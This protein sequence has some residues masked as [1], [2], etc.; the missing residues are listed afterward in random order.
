MTTTGS[1]NE[2]ISCAL[3]AMAGLLVVLA[4][5]ALVLLTPSDPLGRVTLTAEGCASLKLAGGNP[6]EL[7]GV[8]VV[9]GRYHRMLTG[10]TTLVLPSD[11][12]VTLSSRAVL[13]VTEDDSLKTDEDVARQ[14]RGFLVFG[15]CLVAAALCVWFA[16]RLSRGK[17]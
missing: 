9:S 12:E 13:M 1:R 7:D 10:W 5:L 15:G 2:G 4:P 8:C 14:R 16:V 6:Q 11:K 17:D 3:T